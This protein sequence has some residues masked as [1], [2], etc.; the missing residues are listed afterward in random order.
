MISQYLHICMKGFI[1][2]FMCSSLFLQQRPACLVCLIWTFLEMEGCWLYSCYFVR[3]CFQDLFNI[4]RSILVQFL[5]SFFSIYLVSVHLG[6][7]YSRI[8]RA[9]I[10][11]H[12]KRTFQ[13]MFIHLYMF[14]L[15]CLCLYIV[16]IDVSVAECHSS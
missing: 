5:S 12:T 3:C 8:S 16:T 13:Q 11:T 10:H 1:W 4:V 2:E 7:P 9:H 6:P 14:I 15:I